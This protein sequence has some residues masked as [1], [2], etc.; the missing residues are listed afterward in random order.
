MHKKPTKT[1]YKGTV[2]KS[3]TEAIFARCLDLA[4][5]AY[6]YEPAIF[7]ANDGYVPD[8]VVFDRDMNLYIIELKPS[9]PTEVYRDKLA[10]YFHTLNLHVC[11]K[12]IPVL[13]VFNPWEG[14]VSFS[15]YE[16]ISKRHGMWMGV[17]R[18]PECRLTRGIKYDMRFAKK[19][20]FDLSNL[21]D[22][23][24]ASVTSIL[25][26]DIEKKLSLA[27]ERSE[28]W[29]YVFIDDVN[30][31]EADEYWRF[32]LN[33]TSRKW[34]VDIGKTHSG[35]D[36]V[37]ICDAVGGVDWS[38]PVTQLIGKSLAIR[39]CDITNQIVGFSPVI[40]ADC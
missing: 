2:Y 33:T 39:V 36:F 9:E 24:D 3:K 15:T 8:F 1:E 16:I 21:D 28:R 5:C 20:R 23:G 27:S 13:I 30:H 29:H 32:V 17:L 25:S 18:S 19:Y 12:A 40:P 34:F 6:K 37:S 11:E 31:Y 26:G 35:K 10:N 7:K 4:G 14:H 22:S 38:K